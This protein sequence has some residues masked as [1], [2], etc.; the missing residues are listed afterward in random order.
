M[1]VVFG[2]LGLPLISLDV[3]LDFLPNGHDDPSYVTTVTFT[4]GDAD[5]D[6]T[7][8]LDL[9]TYNPEIK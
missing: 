2:L 7:L 9:F 4:L 6:V 1:D 3:C 5:D 8:S